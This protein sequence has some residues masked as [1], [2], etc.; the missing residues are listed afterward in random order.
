MPVT[1]G[2]QSRLAGIVPALDVQETLMSPV[3]YWSDSALEI[4]SVFFLFEYHSYSPL[5]S[6][7]G[8]VLFV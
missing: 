3:H 7:P 4:F 1:Q 8:W 2:V 6:W 5:E